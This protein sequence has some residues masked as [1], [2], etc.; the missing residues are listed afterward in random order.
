MKK[1]LSTLTEGYGV[2]GRG[3]IIYLDK[4][5]T[6]PSFWKYLEVHLRCE[7]FID[8]K[9]IYFVLLDSYNDLM[10]VEY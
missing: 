4:Q 10:L 1:T 5:G 6:L 2:H 7:D 9:S 3:I 8:R